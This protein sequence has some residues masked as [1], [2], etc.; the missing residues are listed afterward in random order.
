MDDVKNYLKISI[1]KTGNRIPRF[2]GTGLD[3][4]WRNSFF[5]WKNFKRSFKNCPK[6]FRNHTIQKTYYGIVVGK[7]KE[8]QGIIKEKVNK[9]SFFAEGFTNKQMRTFYLK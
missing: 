8:R 6:Q 9:I 4:R 7:P 5:V 1:K 3:N 2:G